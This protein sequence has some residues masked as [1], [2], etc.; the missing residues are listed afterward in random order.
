MRNLCSL[1]HQSEEIP[2]KITSKRERLSGL[3][4]SIQIDLCFFL[5][6]WWVREAWEEHVVEQNLSLH[7]DQ[8]A[9]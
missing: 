5:G 4:V 8:E 7:G 3:R 1:A 2:R 6:L 9:V